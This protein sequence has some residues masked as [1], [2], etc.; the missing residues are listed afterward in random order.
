MYQVLVEVRR[1]DGRKGRCRC[2]EEGGAGLVAN[3]VQSSLGDS[4]SNALYK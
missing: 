2:E 4:R 1:L 3:N